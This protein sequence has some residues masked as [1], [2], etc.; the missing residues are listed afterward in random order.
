MSA[1]SKLAVAKS[2]DVSGTTLLTQA[3][4]ILL[5]ALATALGARVEIPHEPVPFTLQTLV[6]LLAGAFLGTRNGVLSQITYLAAGVMGAPVFAGG[7]F[8]AAR[9]LGPSGGYLLA[10]PIAAA[11]VGFLIGRRTSLS[12]RVL[13]MAA[14]L[15]VIFVLGTLHLYVFT[16]H[17]FGAAV[18]SGFFIFSWWDGLKLG[19]AAMTYQEV[20]KRWGKVP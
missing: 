5:F 9:L 13:T 17:N 11:L 14:G 20:A 2:I 1:T 19:A 6:V 15:L 16:L 8:G 7:A 3:A 4:W 10:F 18:S 12:W